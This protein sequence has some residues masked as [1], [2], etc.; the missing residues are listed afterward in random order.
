VVL[1][2]TLTSTDGLDPALNVFAEDVSFSSPSSA[3]GLVF[4]GSQRGPIVWWTEDGSQTYREWQEARLKQPGV[5]VAS[6]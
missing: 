2:H 3:S 5:K 6:G 4:G 1:S